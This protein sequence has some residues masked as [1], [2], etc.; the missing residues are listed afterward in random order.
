M[1]AFTS[2]VPASVS[3]GTLTRDTFRLPKLLPD[4][5]RQVQT[6]QGADAPAERACVTIPN[7]AAAS[8]FMAW[9]S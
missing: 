7:L 5:G 4:L 9:R 2:N 1:F 8:G 3:T 6:A